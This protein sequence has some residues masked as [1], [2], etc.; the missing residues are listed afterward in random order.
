MLDA[1]AARAAVAGRWGSFVPCKSW[2]LGTLPALREPAEPTHK[3]REAERTFLCSVSLTPSADLLLPRCQL[4]KETLLEGTYPFSGT[5]DGF[6]ANVVTC[7]GSN[8]VSRL[9]FLSLSQYRAPQRWLPSGLPAPMLWWHE[10]LG[11]PEIVT[12]IPL[13]SNVDSD[14]SDF[15]QSHPRIS[16]AG[17]WVCGRV[18]LPDIRCLFPYPY[19]HQSAVTRLKRVVLGRPKQVRIN[20]GTG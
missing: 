14:L 5:R 7:K 9:C 17:V 6:R 11:L 2:G 20:R 4:A 16:V 10:E 18:P 12:K 3:S 19:A 13:L 1:E 15:S 8:D